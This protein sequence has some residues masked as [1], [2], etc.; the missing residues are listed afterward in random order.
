MSKRIVIVGADHSLRRKL[1]Q[2]LAGFIICQAQKSVID[3]V[4]DIQEPTRLS[5]HDKPDNKARNK[6][7]KQNQKNHNRR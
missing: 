4:S 1:T 2:A 5:I 3:Q 6:Q 7:W